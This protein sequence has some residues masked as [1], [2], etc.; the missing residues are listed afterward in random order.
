MI[1]MNGKEIIENEINKF[2]KSSL[3]K[4]FEKIKIN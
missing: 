2:L 4:K 1:E 3:V